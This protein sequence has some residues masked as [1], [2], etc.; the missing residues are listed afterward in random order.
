MLALAARRRTS[1]HSLRAPTST[2]GLVGAHRDEGVVAAQLGV[3]GADG[4]DQVA[5]VVAGDQVG[6]DLG[7]GLGA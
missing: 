7:V 3:G 4:L 2:S 5:V 1:G 6:D